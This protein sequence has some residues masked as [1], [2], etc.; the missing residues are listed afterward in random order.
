MTLQQLEYV[1]ALDTYRH[2]VTAAEHTF[3]SQPNLTMQ[4]KKLEEEIGVTIFDRD[5]KPLEPTEI[6]FE[7]ISRSREILR[8]VGQLKQFVSTEK[9]AIE[10]EFHLG[11]I[12]TLAP[13]LLPMFLPEFIK[14]NTKTRLKIQ[15]MQSEQII[16]ELKSGTLD[17]GLLVTPLDENSIR[18]IPLFYEPFLLYLPANHELSKKKRPK[19]EDLNPRE[20]LVLEEGHCFREQSLVICKHKFNKTNIGFDYQSGSIE[21]LKQLVQCGIGYTLIPEMAVTSD[22]DRASVRRFASPEPVREV[23]IVVH[24]N[25]IKEAIVQKVHE[26]ITSQIPDKFKKA[27]KSTVR[28][29]WR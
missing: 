13:Y 28:I 14:H 24:Q 4:V 27:K 20:I 5:K 3:V 25:F 29:K 17:I 7:I 23:S 26:S 9:E 18:E 19:T 16:D 6:G 15:E 1:V 10:G 22:H 12:P 11:I 2:Y 8:E 21:A